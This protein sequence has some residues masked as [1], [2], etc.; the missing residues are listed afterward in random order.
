MQTERLYMSY[1][2]VTELHDYQYLGDNK[3]EREK[4][5]RR[6]RNWTEGLGRMKPPEWLAVMQAISDTFPSG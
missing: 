3:H 4:I 5:R 2:P 1:G 6:V